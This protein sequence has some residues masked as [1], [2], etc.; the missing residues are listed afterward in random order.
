MTEINALVAWEVEVDTYTSIVFA[1]TAPKARWIAVRGYW[2]AGYGRGP[3]NWPPGV[4]AWRCERH[5]KSPLRDRGPKCW[6]PSYVE[7]LRP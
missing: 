7:E 5:D 6:T 2:E 4:S 3:G 1:T